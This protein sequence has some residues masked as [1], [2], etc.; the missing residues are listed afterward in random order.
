MK[1]KEI[2][3]YIPKNEQEKIDKEA[4]IQFASR[5][6]DAF[7]RSNLMAHFTNSAIITNSKKDKVLFINHL[8]YKSW[9]WVGGHN[10]GIEDFLAVVL[11]EATEETGVKN[12]KPLLNE[13]VSLD[14]IFVPY[15]IKNGKFVGD[16]IHMNLAYLLV[17]DENEQLVTKVDENSGVRWF[18]LDEALN[19]V[20]E[21]RMIYIYKKI[22]DV[23]KSLK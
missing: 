13:P 11:R 2:E 19:Y 14:N 22:F 7:L 18:T 3:N 23:L 15:H 6:E 10:D 4:M 16:H 5:N 21:E 12:V 17:A 1:V 9:G 8:I 20:T